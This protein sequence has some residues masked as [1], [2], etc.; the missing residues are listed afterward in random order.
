MIKLLDIDQPEDKKEI[1]DSLAEIN[2]ILK[3]KNTQED[4]KIEIAK[5]V[6]D[7]EYIDDIGQKRWQWSYGY[8]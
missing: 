2:D 7:K 6:E 3:S 5:E 8:L 4:E 1:V